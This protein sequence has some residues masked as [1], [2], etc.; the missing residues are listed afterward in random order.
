MTD[1][2]RTAKSIKNVKVAIIFYVVN[3][4]LQF[5]SRKVFLDYLGTEV[6]GLNTTATNLLSF[7]NLAESGIDAA[8]SYTLYKPLFN[9]DTTAINEIISVQGW[10]YRRVA[11]FITI[12]ACLLMCF[13]PMIFEKAR[14]PMW[15]TYASFSVLL[16][17]ALLGYVYNYKQVVLTADQKEYKLTI[18]IQGIKVI[19]AVLQIF[20]IIYLHHGYVYWLVLEFLM[21]IGTT[22]A[23]NHVVHRE[24][25]WL[26]PLPQMGKILRKKHSEIIK[27]TKQI[28][29]HKMGTFVFGQSSTII[30]YG[31]ASLSL[32]AIY[33][34]YMLITIGV[35][36]L[37]DAVFNSIGAGI[38]NLIAEN[39]PKHTVSIFNE[40]FSLRFFI[41]TIVCYAFYVLV[42]PF[43]TLWIGA[44]Y[45]LDNTALLLIVAALFIDLIRKGIDPFN[46]GYGLYQD[47]WAT[48]TESGLNIGL[49]IWFGSIWGCTAS[50]REDW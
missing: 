5:F 35:H 15:Y 18:H 19:K 23:I 49:P 30:I 28:F 12:G 9:K 14:V 4:V 48:L 46:N 27:K 11:A 50:W 6:L 32:V 29:F 44:D 42:N 45:L 1:S 8:V 38:G 10:L 37:I 41:A 13:F 25:P 3:L 21:A 31:Y 2:S 24:Y 26:H 16:F 17:S 22:I 34:N 47:V 7:L 20:A 43:I 40:L 39:K 33:G 36:L